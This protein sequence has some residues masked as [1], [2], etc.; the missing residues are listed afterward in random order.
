M[1]EGVGV[2]LISDEC[3]FLEVMADGIVD[4]WYFGYVVSIH[5]FIVELFL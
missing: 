1:L 2:H 3:I 5:L 4:V